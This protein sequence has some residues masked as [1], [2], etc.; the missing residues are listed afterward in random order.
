MSRRGAFDGAQLIRRIAHGRPG[1]FRLDGEFLQ[2]GALVPESALRPGPD[3]PVRPHLLEVF[4]SDQSR[5]GHGGSRIDVILWVYESDDWRAVC[6][7]DGYDS[8]AWMQIM[9]P[10][11]TQSL[12]ESRDDVEPIDVHA[13]VDELVAPIAERLAAIETREEREALATALYTR[14]MF[15]VCGELGG[16]VAG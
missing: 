9:E 2:P 6:R 8:S 15:V 13:V 10:V 3:W 1:A 11:I 16:E 5:A 7:L 12:K 4:R 14:L